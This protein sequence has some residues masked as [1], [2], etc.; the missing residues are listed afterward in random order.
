VRK[1]AG[2]KGAITSSDQKRVSPDRK[3]GATG[4]I[5][6]YFSSPEKI[7]QTSIG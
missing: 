5:S 6:Q 2:N 1:L 4:G 7:V 3:Y